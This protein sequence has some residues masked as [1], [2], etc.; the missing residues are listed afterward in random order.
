VP[1]VTTGAAASDPV[2]DTPV[3][4][5]P[6]SLNVHAR[7]RRGRAAPGQR[8]EPGEAGDPG[9]DDDGAA[10]REDHLLLPSAPDLPR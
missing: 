6:V 3:A 7:R 1:P 5:V 4:A 8:A 2:L 10:P 9:G